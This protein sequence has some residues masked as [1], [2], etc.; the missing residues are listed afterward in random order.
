[1]YVND[2]NPP[3]FGDYSAGPM[4]TLASTARDVIKRMQLHYP[5]PFGRAQRGKYVHYDLADW[6]QPKDVQ[7]CFEDVYNSIG[8]KWDP[9]E[10][11]AQVAG[12]LSG[13]TPGLWTD[14]F[15]RVY[16]L[17]EA[18]RGGKSKSRPAGGGEDK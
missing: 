18:I 12:S 7:A 1:V 16:D 14:L 11:S 8:K 6:A 10:L 5:D 3:T 15:D 9:N 2:V 4:Q 17:A 13:L